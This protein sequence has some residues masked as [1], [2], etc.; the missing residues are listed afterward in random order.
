MKIINITENNHI[1]PLMVKI[2]EHCC[3]I[4]NEDCEQTVEEQFCTINCKD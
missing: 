1:A 2:G 4:Y 3:I